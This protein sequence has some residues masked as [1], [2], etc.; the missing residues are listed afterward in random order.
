MNYTT[1]H[2][3][4]R[5]G[6][7]TPEYRA[8][9]AARNRCNNPKND[10]YEDYGGRGIY[11]CERW[12]NFAAFLEDMGPRPS[13]QHT[14]ERVKNDYGYCKD[15]CVWATR[16][17]QANNRRGLTLTFQGVTKTRPQWAASLGMSLPGLIYRLSTHSLEEALTTPKHALGAKS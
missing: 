13:S 5:K 3:H 9:A 16:K 6:H 12:N 17:E 14:L 4:N 15:N 2:G 8:W 11:M 1:K 7:R 10:A